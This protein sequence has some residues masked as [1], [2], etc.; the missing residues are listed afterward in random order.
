VDRIAMHFLARPAPLRGTVAI[1][2]SKS[3]TIRGVLLA[4]LAEG[5]SVLLEPLASADTQAAVRVYQALGASFQLGEREWRIRGVGRHFRAPAAPLDVANSGT[6]M[7][8]ALGTCALLR[9]GSVVL[10]GDHQIQRRPSANLAAAL[11]DLGARITSERGNGCPPFRVQGTLRG[12]RTS[13]EA[14]SSQYVTSLLFA[15]PLAEDESTIE[16]PVLHERPYVQ[17]TLDWLA[18]QGIAVAHEGLQHF[19]IPGGQTFRPFTRKIPADFST[20]TFFLVAGA[21]PGNRIT[22]TGLDLHDSQSDKQVVTFLRR[23]GAEVTVAGDAIT[24]AAPR[25]LHGQEL[26]LNDCPDALPMMAVCGCFAEGTTTLCNV[27]H[28]RIKETDRIAVMCQELRRLGAYIGERPDGLVI[29]RSQLRAAAV[30]GHADHRVVMS[31]ALAGTQLA[32]T[33]RVATAEAAAVTCPTFR[34]Q[35]TALGGLL[36]QAE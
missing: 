36:D 23:M 8:V 30:D 15:C 9:E 24:V 31:L 19:R 33:T 2:G 20:A 1:P 26:D 5:E 17:M 4:S 12:G 28:A 14:P 25:G 34:E 10:T 22:C 35:L 29:R 13:L 21:F 27:A 7:N 18:Y 6:T 32:G 11:N 3:H 16:V